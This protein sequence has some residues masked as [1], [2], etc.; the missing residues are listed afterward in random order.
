MA[1]AKQFKTDF[2]TIRVTRSAQ[3]GRM[4]YY[5]NGSFHSQTNR[6]G[7]SLCAYVH[8]IDEIIRQHHAHHVLIIGCAGGSIATMLRR[9]PCKVTTVDINPMAFTIARR[10]F[11]MP[12][13]VRCIRRDGIA[14]LRTTRKKY[15]A[16]IVDVFGGNNHVPRGFTTEDFFRRV[17]KVLSPSGLMIM[18]IMTADDTDRQADFIAGHA[19]KSHMNVALFDW[20]GEKHRNTLIVGGG[21]THM[22]IPSGYEP[23]WI[24]E[25]LKGLVKKTPKRWWAR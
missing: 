23:R 12:E 22:H 3:D 14:H 15:D 7:I 8:V 9:H 25:D 2:G 20:P 4:T 19:Q 21:L 11:K 6:H 16:V 24:R 13:D 1:F 10:Y 18:N 5:Q 17:Q